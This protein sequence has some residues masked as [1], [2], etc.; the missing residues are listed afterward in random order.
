MSRER[1]RIEVR[2]VVDLYLGKEVVVSLRNRAKWHRAE[3]R[4]FV[5][6]RLERL[7]F[8]IENKVFAQ[9]NSHAGF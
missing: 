6:K 8:K 9:E 7:A 1:N 5:A 3:R 4:E 2:S